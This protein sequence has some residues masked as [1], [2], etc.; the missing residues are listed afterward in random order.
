MEQHVSVY[1]KTKKESRGDPHD[2]GARGKTTCTHQM[3]LIVDSV[4]H[5]VNNVP[6]VQNSHNNEKKK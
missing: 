3:K 5:I 4:D 2:K 6:S 1:L